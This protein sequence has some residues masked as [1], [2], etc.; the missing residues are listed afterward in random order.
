M[1]GDEIPAALEEFVGTDLT[2]DDDDLQI[3]T[4]WF[5][6]D[7]ELP[8]GGAPAERYAA[9]PELPADERAAASRIASARLGVHRVLAVE[10]GSSIELEDVVSGT[11]VRV[12]S[13]NVSRDAVRW[14]ILLGR[15]MA[16]DPP[17]LWGPTRFFEPHEERELLAELERLATQHGCGT[18]ERGLSAALRRGALDLMRFKPPSW[19]VKP[20]FFTLEGNPVAEARATWRVRDRAAA[21]ARIGAL[22]GLAAGEPEDLDEIDICVPREALVANRPELPAG[23]VVLEAGA[24]GDLDRVPV[25]TVRFEADQLRVETMSAQRLERAIEMVEC[26]LGDLVELTEREAI[27][28]ERRLEDARAEPRP[29]REAPPGL[30]AAEERSIVEDHISDRFHRWLDEPHPGLDG[31]TPREAVAGRSRAEVVRLVRGIENQSER[32]RRRGEAAPEV[33]WLRGELGLEGELAA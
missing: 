20:S 17:S 16:G 15:V 1:L 26:D 13:P 6:S 12:R 19:S 18:D 11:R 8:G 9:R 23:A 4:T 3:F 31:Q 14:D 7:R 24:V 28:I 25:A 32:A 33:A 27:P 10:S 5:H 21:G 22:A 29:E 2:M 30:T